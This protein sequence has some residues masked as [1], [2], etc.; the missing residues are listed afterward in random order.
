MIKWSDKNQR[1]WSLAFSLCFA[2]CFDILKVVT[3]LLPRWIQ[4]HTSD[5]WM[6]Q[7]SRFGFDNWTEA[8]VYEANIE[9]GDDGKIDHHLCK[10]CTE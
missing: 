9:R 3:P 2:A 10:K 5:E 7:S 6:N 4:R 1:N 8:G